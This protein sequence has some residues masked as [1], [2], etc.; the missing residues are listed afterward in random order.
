MTA[1]FSYPHVLA[2]ISLGLCFS[3]EP[4]FAAG[5]C[6]RLGKPSY[7][8]DRTVEIGGATIIS[9][10]YVSPQA[11]REELT[12]N[13]RAEV[14]IVSA[15]RIVSFNLEN[16]TG[17]VQTTPPPP[18]PA[19]GKVRVREEDQGGAKVYTIELIDDKGG[20]NQIARST[21]RDDG[22]LLDKTFAVPA[23]GGAGTL[24][25]HMTQKIIAVGP[26]DPALFK[27]PAQVKIKR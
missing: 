27:A 22:V 10:V 11:E 26:L 24:T 21:C 18:R 8:A 19:K 4:A 12:I 25:G 15:G 16:N 20:W 5:E 3:I 9:K 23:P 13:G 17:V 2:L 6:A 7:T 1:R 14:R